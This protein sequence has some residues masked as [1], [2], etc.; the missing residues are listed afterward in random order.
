MTRQRDAAAERAA[1]VE[2]R[3]RRDGG[4]TDRDAA[5]PRTAAAG[6]RH[7]SDQGRDVMR[8]LIATAGSKSC[9]LMRLSRNSRRR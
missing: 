3:R 9:A 1:D 5:A 6:A 4:G 7:E 8:P 2:H